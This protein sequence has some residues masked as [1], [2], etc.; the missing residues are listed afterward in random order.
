MGRRKTEDGAVATEP[1]NG[2][3]ALTTAFDAQT[4]AEASTTNGTVSSTLPV[5]EK[6][7]VPGDKPWVKLGPYP[8]SSKGTFIGVAIW[9][10]EVTANDTGE[11]FDAFSVSLSRTYHDAAGQPKNSSSLRSGDIQLALLL[12]EKADRLIREHREHTKVPNGH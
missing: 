4:A 5:G 6:P 9:K 11:V 7:Q 2:V 3:E 12:L 8:T 10:K 1:T